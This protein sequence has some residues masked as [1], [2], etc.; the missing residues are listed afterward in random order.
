[1]RAFGLPAWARTKKRGQLALAQID[2]GI[3]GAA[4][5]LDPIPSAPGGWGLRKP[6]PKGPGQRSASLFASQSGGGRA[7]FGRYYDLSNNGV[8]PN[9]GVIRACR[10]GN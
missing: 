3:K 2:N 6:V 4:K 7:E 9:G 8:M 1:M 5:K 10:G